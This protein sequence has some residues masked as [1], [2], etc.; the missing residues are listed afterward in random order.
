MGISWDYI[1]QPNQDIVFNNGSFFMLIFGLYMLWIGFNAVR[2]Q[3]H[4]GAYLP[5]NTGVRAWFTFIAGMGI[6]VPSFIA[7]EYAFE[8]GSTPVGLYGLNG[9]TFAHL[10]KSVTFYDLESAFRVLETPSIFIFG[11]V[12]LG[13]SAF[14]PFKDFELR[15]LY[16]F[17]LGVTIGPI[18]ALLVLPAYWNGNREDYMKF[19]YAYCILMI[20]L[21]IAI[22]LN[23][24][25]SLI[26]SVVS[27]ILIL[28]GQYLDFSEQ[29]RG[30]AWLEDRKVN[31][32][33]SIFG[34]GNP[35]FIVGWILL[36]HG[37]SLP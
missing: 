14:M 10:S 33:L 23:G 7:L 13:F 6:I 31:E 11:W 36:C 5:I 20:S 35:L 25:A 29:K 15:Q 8:R 2:I 27:V 28:L 30:K 18:Y 26:M 24:G 9:D 21:A 4:D 37:L 12:M 17:F 34:I 16:V 19:M 1:A 3:D 22:G 32:N